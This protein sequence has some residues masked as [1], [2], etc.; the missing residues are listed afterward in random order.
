MIVASMLHIM[1]FSFNGLDLKALI[2]MN[3][4][5]VELKTA[6]V[7]LFRKKHRPRTK[8]Y[9]WTRLKNYTIN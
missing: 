3:V 9:E 1:D 5:Q 8:G 2:V 4:E 7:T 6:V